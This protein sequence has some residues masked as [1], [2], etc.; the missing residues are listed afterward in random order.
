MVWHI[1]YMD[2]NIKCLQE[3]KGYIFCLE[4]RKLV[5]KDCDEDI[6]RNS[7]YG[8][9]HQRFL[10]AGLKLALDPSDPIPTVAPSSSS[11]TVIT[12]PPIPQPISDHH[13]HRHHHHDQLVQYYWPP[14]LDFQFSDMD[15]SSNI[16]NSS[17]Y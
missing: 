15:D 3:K 11:T 9:A 16:S 12:S 14:E 4:D 6:H 1:T 7:P 5:C 8:L 10:I 13:D 2:G 17:H